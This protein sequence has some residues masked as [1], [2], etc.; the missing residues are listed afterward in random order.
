[1]SRTDD[2]HSSL[3]FGNPFRLL[4]SR[5]SHISPKFLV[6]LN[7]FELMLARSLTSLKPNDPSEILG[8]SWMSQAA[9]ALAEIHTNIKA[10][11][12]D[13]QFPISDWDNRWMDVYLNDS[14]KLLDI[15]IAL[16]SGLSRLDRGQFLLQHI[17]LMLNNTSNFT[18]S[19][20]LKSTDT[21]L[22]ELIVLFESRSPDLEH[23]YN[24][25]QDLAETLY[26]G[27]PKNSS[28]EKVL[29][30]ALYG[31]KV[32]T[33]FICN[34]IIAA[35]SGFSKPLIQLR[36]P[37]KFL[38][39]KA[40]DELRVTVES[41]IINHPW[42]EKATF[43]KDLESVKLCTE[44]LQQSFLCIKEE[45]SPQVKILNSERSEPV[46]RSA[47]NEHKAEGISLERLDGD[48]ER[49]RLVES[50]IALS[51][52]AEKLFEGVDILSKRVDDFFQIVLTGR[53]ALLANLRGADDTR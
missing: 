10:L 14:I 34:I 50:V 53:D 32:E 27:K 24:I 38:W 36:V 44:R 12:T 22:H 15:C 23:C 8:F 19:E 35:L 4:F 33:I 9:E 40:F 30:R 17:L 21:S 45:K 26:M 2:G 13:L 41:E 3:P 16:S 49:K 11:I 29:M 46:E 47:G 31:V 51:E 20:L 25:L 7:D 52:R 5:K 48:E 37:E 6:L 18:S 28:K 42:S 43:L 39:S 1:M